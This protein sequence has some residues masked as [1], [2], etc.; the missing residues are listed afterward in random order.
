MIHDIITWEMKEKKIR[1]LKDS[2][3]NRV[4]KESGTVEGKKT[5]K[6]FVLGKMKRTNEEES[7]EIVLNL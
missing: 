2:I 6:C 5:K 3:V 4:V 1:L 7:E